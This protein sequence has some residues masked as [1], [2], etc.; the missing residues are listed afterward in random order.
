MIETHG[1]QTTSA[2]YSRLGSQ[3]CEK[4]HMASIEVLETIGLEVHYEKAREILVEAGAKAEGQRVRIPEHMVTRALAT[5]PKKMILF[6]RNGRPAIRAWGHQSY[7]GGGSD[8]LYVLDHRTGERRR[9]VL[10]DVIDAT[11]LMDALPQVDFIMSAFLPSDVSEPVYP[12]FQ[13]EVMLTKSTKPIV[14]VTPDFDTCVACVEMAEI[15]AGGVKQFQ[16][17]PFAVCYINVT[18]GMVANTDSLK[19]CI[20]FAEKGLP[21]LYI[22]L[23]AAGVNSP[24]TTAGCMATMNAGT[25]LGIVLSQLVREG[26]PIA[27]PGWNGGPYNLQTMVGNYCLP[28]EQGV[29]ASMGRYYQLPVFGLGGSTDSKVLDQQAGAECAMGLAF[30][31]LNGAN[32]IHD[33]GFMDAGLQGSLQL[34]VISNDLLGWLRAATAGVLVNDETLAMDVV[35]ELGPEGDYLSHDHTYRHYKDAYY[36]KLADRQIY[37]AWQD[38]G[39]TSMGERAS[40]QVE[41]ILAGHKVD[42]AVSDEIRQALRNYVLRAEQR[43][44][45]S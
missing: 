37:S 11:K 2:H 32:I 10:Q 12:Q 5:A 24:A 26:S 38:A 23:N 33:L 19:K 34:M 44:S 7:F 20:Y 42:A 41:E 28:D 8:C 39:S 1:L 6:D 14:F 9:A 30:S 40:K 17:R 45:H 4:L 15:A 22:P 25:L 27:V 18:S 36:S 21:Q 13:M 43:A 3:E 16:A 31:M 29:A 35:D